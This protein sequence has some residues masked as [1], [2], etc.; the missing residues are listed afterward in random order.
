[1]QFYFDKHLEREHHG[2][3]VIG[4]SQ[5]HSL[6]AVWRD[7]RSLH[8][9]RDAVERYEHEHQVVEPFLFDELSAR[10]SET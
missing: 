2:E 3:D 7:V 1:M 9:Q 4:R 10:L 5:K 8:G 6:S